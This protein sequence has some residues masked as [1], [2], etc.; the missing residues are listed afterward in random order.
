MYY[1]TVAKICHQPIQK[2][3]T[4]KK[5]VRVCCESSKGDEN[6]VCPM[7][8][9]EDENTF[10]VIQREECTPCNTASPGRHSTIPFDIFMDRPELSS[11]HSFSYDKMK[12]LY[13]MLYCPRHTYNLSDHNWSIY[14]TGDL[15][16]GNAIYNQTNYCI[17]YGRKLEGGEYIL[18]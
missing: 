18:Y 8:I 6:A 17:N 13:G 14:P 5:G 1:G 12:F 9:Q 16:L 4:R 11:S 15:K 2:Q 3:L 10:G 7:L